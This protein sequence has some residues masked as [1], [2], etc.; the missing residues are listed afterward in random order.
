MADNL[1]SVFDA[2][3]NLLATTDITDVTSESSF[4][5]DLPDGYYLSEV[6]KTEI[7][8]SKSTHNPMIMFQYK[9]VENG[10]TIDDKGKLVELKGTA[11]R[12]IFKN[13]VFKDQDSVK[14]FVTD[15]LKFEG[16][17]P[18]EPVLEKE[19]FMNSEV[20]ED[21]LD[22]LV[23]LRLYIHARVS[24][25]GDNKSTWFDCISWKRASAMGLPA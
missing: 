4:F 8:E 10:V 6:V 23:G 14:R 16:D 20:L 21:A 12:N 7:K 18:G 24:G 1:K 22:V 17:V 13:Y 5:Q 3:D 2:L 9:I 11:K 25:E 15:M 19:A